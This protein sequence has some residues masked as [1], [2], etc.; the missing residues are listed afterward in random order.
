M[1][2]VFAPSCGLIFNL[3]KRS[4]LKSQYTVYT[5]L[6]WLVYQLKPLDWITHVYWDEYSHIWH[7]YIQYM[8]TY[9]S[10][11]YAP[12]STSVPCFSSTAFLKL[13]LSVIVVEMLSLTSRGV[14]APLVAWP[15]WLG[16]IPSHSHTHC[17][18]SLASLVTRCFPVYIRHS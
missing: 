10:Y 15:T 17:S 5:G 14:M 7:T 1:H 6:Q 13:S 18:I 9:L 12:G 3:S 4:R 16:R 11:E 8:V 2:R